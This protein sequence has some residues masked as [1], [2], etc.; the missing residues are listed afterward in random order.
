M[1]KKEGKGSSSEWVA[2][3]VSEWLKWQE[4][5]ICLLL[6][7]RARRHGLNSQSVST[8]PTVRGI[9]EKCTHT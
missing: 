2:A 5:A 4:N 3:T 8:C 9:S 7:S 1:R 6:T